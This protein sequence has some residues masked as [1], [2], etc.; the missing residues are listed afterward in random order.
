MFEDTKMIEI[1]ESAE[2]STDLNNWN[3][4]SDALHRE[5]RSVAETE[6]PGRY[7]KVN[8]KISSSLLG[9]TYSDVYVSRQPVPA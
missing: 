3:G 9:L 2:K 7:V 4:D 8:A 1:K 5:T 6:K